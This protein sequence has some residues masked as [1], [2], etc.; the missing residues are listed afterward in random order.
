MGE[1]GRAPRRRSLIAVTAFC[2]AAAAVPAAAQSPPPP[3]N[4]AFKPSAHTRALQRAVG[5]GVPTKK[6]STK[7]RSSSTSSGSSGAAPRAFQPLAAPSGGITPVTHKR[8]S[9]HHRKHKKHSTGSTY[10]PPRT[11][12]DSHDRTTFVTKVLH[13]VPTGVWIGLLVLAALAGALAAGSIASAVRARRLRRQRE[14]LRADVGLLQSALLPVVPA[15]ISG[16]RVSAAYR[17]AG[18][19]AAGGDFYDLFPL[20]G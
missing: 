20:A 2:L 9:K 16:V 3:A 15:E 18:G 8:H 10:T 1:S 14:V 19:P 11:T 6:S 7:R 4:S 5:A 12:T 13:K 17:P